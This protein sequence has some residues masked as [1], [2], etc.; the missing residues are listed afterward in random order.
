MIVVVL[1]DCPPK[2]RGDLS[3]WLFEIN[4]GVYVG[5][6]NARI[7]EALWNRICENLKHGQATMV[8]P[9]QCE[10][11]MEFRVH[12]TSW[13]IADF[14]GLKLTEMQNT[15]NSATDSAG[16]RRCKRRGA[17]RPPDAARRRQIR[18]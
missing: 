10:Q 18:T 11:K 15:R 2:L 13:E 9:A 17:Y 1:T 12:N 7:R 8:Y 6:V 14:D 16:P 3:K 5:R 4:T